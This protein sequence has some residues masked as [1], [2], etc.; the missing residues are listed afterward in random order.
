MKNAVYNLKITAPAPSLWQDTVV[1]SARTYQDAVA[2]AQDTWRRV[3]RPV[4]LGSGEC[5]MY[6]WHRID[7]KG[8]AIDRNTN[9]GVPAVAE[10]R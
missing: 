6:F 7:S 4:C 9:S 10:V 8:M 2:V 3:R 5:G 1:F